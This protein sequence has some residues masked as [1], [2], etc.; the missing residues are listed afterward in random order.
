VGGR[1]RIGQRDIKAL[2]PGQVVWDSAVIGFGARRQ[3]SEAVSYFVFYRTA[4]GRQRWQTIGRH[5][6]PWVPDI[7]RD[8]ARRLL[9]DVARGGTLQP[10]S[11]RF[12][13]QS[14][15]LSGATATWP[16]PRLG[17]C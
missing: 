4:E 2:R 6:A 9:G 14:R 10:Q 16:M 3:R 11:R 5:G 15:L 8:E 1:Q 12:A 7:A 17:S 13:K